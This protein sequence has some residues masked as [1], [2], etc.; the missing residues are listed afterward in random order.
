M[1]L[2][3][4]V[5]FSL[6]VFMFASS[7][8]SWAQTPPVAPAAGAPAK[9][10]APKPKPVPVAGALLRGKPAYTP[11]QKVGLFLW[12]DTEGIHVRFTNAGKPVLFEGR[13]DLDRPLK[14][15]KRIDEKGPGWAKNNG[16]RIVMFSTTL[17]EGEDGL[18][19]KVPGLRKMLVDLKIDGAPAPIEQIFLGEKSASPTGLPMQI[20]VP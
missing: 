8:P 12:Q 7:V 6:V 10:D 2:R 20:A 18:D 19:L 3:L 16:D 13:L 11:G 1:P 14:E 17:R 4:A 15:L 5:T 9:T